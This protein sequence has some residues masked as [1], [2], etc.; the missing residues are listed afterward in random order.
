MHALDRMSKLTLLHQD[1]TKT[2]TDRSNYSFEFTLFQNYIS[3]IGMKE[4]NCVSLF[5]NAGNE[6]TIDSDANTFIMLWT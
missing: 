3:Y 4:F 5:A 1:T 2:E 6:V